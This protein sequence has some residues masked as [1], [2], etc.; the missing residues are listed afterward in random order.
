VT[1]AEGRCNDLLKDNTI[2]MHAGRY[3]MHYD[4]SQYYA[5]RNQECFFPFIEVIITNLAL[6]CFIVFI[7]TGEKRLLIK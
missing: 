5:I 2:E 1:D 7:V 6:S 4:V 3:K